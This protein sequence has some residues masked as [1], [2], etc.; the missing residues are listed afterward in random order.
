M[1][2]DVNMMVHTSSALG[3]MA[4]GGARPLPTCSMSPQ[5]VTRT[6]RASTACEGEGGGGGGAGGLVGVVAAVTASA[7]W[8]QVKMEGL[9]PKLMPPPPEGRIGCACDVRLD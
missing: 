1:V 4:G 5:L 3:V 8:W 9:G 7:E 6:P 2:P